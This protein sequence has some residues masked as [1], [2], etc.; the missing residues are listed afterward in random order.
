MKEQVTQR[1]VGSCSQPR[2]SVMKPIHARWIVSALDRVAVTVQASH[3][4]GG[5]L[6]Y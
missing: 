5:W 3:V 2:I 6:D 1:Y 4:V